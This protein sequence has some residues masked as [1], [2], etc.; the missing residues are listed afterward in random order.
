[1]VDKEKITRLFSELDEYLLSL[2]ELKNLSI[3]DYLS[4]RRNV[5]SGRYLLQIS[6]D[7]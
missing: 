7:V 5:Y 3:N 2:N 6:I 1:M 4:E